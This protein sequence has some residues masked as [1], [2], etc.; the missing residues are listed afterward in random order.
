MVRLYL[1][2]GRIRD[3]ATPSTN[4]EEEAAWSK[5]LHE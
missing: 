5:V 4:T 1:R 3:Q 2:K